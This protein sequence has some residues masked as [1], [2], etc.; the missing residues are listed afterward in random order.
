MKNILPSLAIL[1]VILGVHLALSQKVTMTSFPIDGLVQDIVW[2][3]QED[4]SNIWDPSDNSTSQPIYIKKTV[5]VLSAK[6][7]VYRSVDEGKNFENLKPK[8]ESASGSS[9]KYF[10]EKNHDVKNARV[11]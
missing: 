2:C 7:T 4:V 3:G 9:A 11:C 8:L 1:L 5:F 10:H 6:G